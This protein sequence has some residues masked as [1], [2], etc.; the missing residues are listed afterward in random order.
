M[1][2]PR[3]WFWVAGA[4]AWVTGGNAARIEV[5]VWLWPTR[6]RVRLAALLM[7]AG[8]LLASLGRNLIPSDARP[9]VTITL[10]DTDDNSEH[11]Y[12]AA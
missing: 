4:P 8:I 5:T 11:E 12:D 1:R 10:G 3:P 9:V 6:A 2:F 7:R